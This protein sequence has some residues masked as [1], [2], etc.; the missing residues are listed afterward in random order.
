MRWLHGITNLMDMSLSK[1]WETVKDREACS[2]WGRKQL[3][4]TE[5]LSDNKSSFASSVSAPVMFSYGPPSRSFF[6]ETLSRKQIH[7]FL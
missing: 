4:T 5:R 7:L 1:L 2:P 3:D 6:A